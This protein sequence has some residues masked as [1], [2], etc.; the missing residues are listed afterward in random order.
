MKLKIKRDIFDKA[1]I[2][3]GLSV[4]AVALE[5]GIARPS[6]YTI[7]NGKGGATPKTAKAI[8]DL[9]EVNISELFEFVE[10]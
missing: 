5:I 8:A 3:K 2:Q 7:T 9:L 6:L 10:E 1:R 4:S